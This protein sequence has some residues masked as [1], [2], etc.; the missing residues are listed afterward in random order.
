MLIPHDGGG[1]LVSR[2]YIDAAW[3]TQNSTSGGSRLS[4]LNALTVIPW[5]APDASRAVRIV[6]PQANRPRTLRKA[7]ESIPPLQPTKT[8]QTSDHRTTSLAGTKFPVTPMRRS[9]RSF[10]ADNRV[11]A[12]LMSGGQPT[13]APITRSTI[14]L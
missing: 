7:S 2:S 4:E 5:S 14:H 1:S 10:L 9:A 8:F 12:R 3:S 13:T 11:A 6:T